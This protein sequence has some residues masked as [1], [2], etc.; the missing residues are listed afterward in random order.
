M[1]ITPLPT[2]P[3]R[4]MTEDVFV[5]TANAF[6][7]ALPTFV[8]ETNATAATVD[9]D[10]AAA[11]QSVTDAAAQV[12][13]AAAQVALAAAQ[14]DLAA[15][16]VTLATTQAGNASTSATASATSASQSEGFKDS[17]E[18]AAAAA[19]AAAGLPALV[20]NAGKFLSVNGDENGVLFDDV[21]VPTPPGMVLLSTQTVTTAVASVDFTGLTDTYDEYVLRIMGLKPSADAILYL[22]TSTDNGATFDAGASDYEWGVVGAAGTGRTVVASSGPKAFLRISPQNNIRFEAEKSG[23]QMQIDFTRDGPSGY[24]FFNW[25]GVASNSEFNDGVGVFH[26]AGRRLSATSINAIRLLFSTGNI[27]VGTFRLYGV[28]K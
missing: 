23:A 18:T 15:D 21:P 8:T 22:R 20:G 3:T 26:G 14:V 11:A 10:K 7:G 27:A 1:A 19:G 12:A 9:A 16:E 25:R 2:P 24:L 28:R 4:D 5:P 17:A 6:I 13:L